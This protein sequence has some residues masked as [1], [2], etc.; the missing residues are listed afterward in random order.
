MATRLKQVRRVPGRPSGES[1]DRFRLTLQTREQHIRLTKPTS[2]VG[3][4]QMLL[5]DMAA[6]KAVHYRTDGLK[7]I[8]KRVALAKLGTALP[9]RETSSDTVTFDV[10]TLSSADLVKTLE[11]KHI[12]KMYFTEDVHTII[13]DLKEA[14]VKGTAEKVPETHA[15][16]KL[17]LQQ[18]I[19]NFTHS[20]T[21]MMRY[22]THKDLFLK[23][24][25]IPFGSCTMTMNSVESLTT[26]SW[27]EV[28]NIHLFALTHNTIG[29]REKMLNF[30]DDACSLPG[31]YAS[32]L[33]IRKYQ[34]SIRKGHGKVCIIPKSAHG[35]KPASAAMC[36]MMVKGE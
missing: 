22:M 34:E 13:A 9:N 19:F 17:Y 20:V 30:L 15:R 35:T 5:S 7:N 28:V 33:V 3:T 2:N 29:Y 11:A 16:T 18:H 36:G 10:T 27:P 32:L 21:E 4:A 12:D 23:T 14:G 26:S 25:T 6:M 31:M 1:L 24:S 8:A